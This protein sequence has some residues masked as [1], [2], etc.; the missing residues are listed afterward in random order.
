MYGGVEWDKEKGDKFALNFD[1]NNYT[2]KD[3][4]NGQEADKIVIDEAFAVISP[5]S[6]AD[7]GS[8][9]LLAIST[10][11]NHTEVTIEGHSRDNI[12][13]WVEQA[14]TGSIKDE[15]GNPVPIVIN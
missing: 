6:E 8:L 5:N 13:G 15:N 14:M 12:R 4:R 3:F 2:I 11:G 7:V 1:N 10:W 9:P